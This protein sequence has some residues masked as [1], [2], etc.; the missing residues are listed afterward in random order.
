VAR[1]VVDATYMRVTVPAMRPPRY[2]VGTDVACVAPNDLPGCTAYD[3]YVVVGAGK[4]GIDT[5]LWLLGHGIAPE[6]LAWIMPRDSWLLDRAAMQPGSMFA[7]RIKSGFIAQLRAI[8]DATSPDDLFARLED[9]GTLLRIDPAVRPTM[10]RCA[11]VTRAELDQLRRIGD[12]VREGHL[13][14]IESDEMVLEGGARAVRGC[15]LYIDCSA[16]GADK[17]A[18]TTIFKPDRIA[19]QSVRGC[20]Q[21]FSASLIAHVEAAYSDDTTRNRLCVPLPHPDTD[22]DWLRL[23]R[24]DYGN[25]LRWFDEPSLTAS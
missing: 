14:G 24:A 19:L 1:R 25:Q 9:A 21:I 17:W 7:D 10:Y 5:C 20:Q 13:L 22:L 23:A 11:T 18:A 2:R 15:T 4:T 6:R 16:D 12:I 3:R 8:R